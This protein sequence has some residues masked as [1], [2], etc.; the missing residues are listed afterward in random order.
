MWPVLVIEQMRGIMKKSEAIEVGC[1]ILSVYAFMQGITALQIPISMHEQAIT[2]VSAAP[3]SIVFIP[4]A[5]L[6]LFSAFLWLSARQMELRSKDQE[7][8]AESASGLTAQV[9]QG[10]VFSALGILMLVESVAPLGNL[11]LLISSSQQ[12]RVIIPSFWLRIVE[13]SINGLVRLALG[14]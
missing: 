6:F 3:S 7:P 10:T 12:Q 9:V 5:L 2:H 8:S 11:V 14:L 4:A 13:G 1:K